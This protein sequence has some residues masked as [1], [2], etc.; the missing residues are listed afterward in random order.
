MSIIKEIAAEAEVSVM[1]VYNVINGNHAKVSAKNIDLINELIKKK[2]Y[3]PNLSAKS[4]TVKSTKIIGVIIPLGDGDYNFFKDPYL[5]EL[6]GVVEHSVRKKGYY[7]MIRSVSLASDVSTLLKTWNM[8][9]A[10]F[11]LP[12]YDKIVHKILAHNNLPMVFLD[13]YSDCPDILSVGINDFKGG[14]IATKYLISMGHRNIA[15]AGPIESEDVESVVNQRFKGYKA[16]LKESNINFLDSFVYPAMPVYDTGVT[17]GREISDRRGEITA[18]LTS[19]DIMAIGIMEGARRNGYVI[20]NDLSIV[21]FDNI[22]CAIFS[23]PKLT[24][25]S[26]NISAKAEYA[27]E[28]L[29]QQIDNGFVTQNRTVMDVEIIERQSVIPLGN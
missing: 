8:D 13:S 12:Y 2:H 14:Y 16:A 25:I 3:V 1:T 21:G 15:F 24:T 18:V 6:I 17:V 28:L 10:I 9:G 23:S 4:L 11:L 29:M 26:Q 5:S 20:P 22:E 19:A 27:I 7:A